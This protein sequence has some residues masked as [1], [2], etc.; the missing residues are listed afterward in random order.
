MSSSRT[1]NVSINMV[2]ALFCQV[3]NLCLNFVSR[4]YFIQALGAEYLGV[5]G[6]FSNVLS[7]LSF[8]ELGIG[9]ALVFSM[10][11]P[12]AVSDHQKLTSLMALY[13]RAYRIIALVVTIAGL[14]YVP[15]IEYTI[16]GHPNIP[17]NLTLIYLLFL[18]NTVVS[19]LVVYK[20]SII[21]ADQKNYIVLIASEIPHIIQIAAQIAVLII[22]H[23]FIGFLVIQIAFT[24][25]GNLACAIIANKKYPYILN[26]PDPLDKE[27]RSEIF[28]NIR[29]MAMYKFGSIILN[30]TDNIIISSMLGVIPV[31]IVSNYVLFHQAANSVIGNI[32]NS[33]TAS[34]GNLNAIASPEKK[35]DIFKKV[36]FIT[37][38]LYGF[39]AS[40]LVVLSQLLIPLWVGVDY[41]LD[42]PT[43]IAIMSGFYV[44]GV[45]TAESHYRMTMGYFVKGKMSPLYSAILNIVL[46]VALCKWIGLIGVFIATPISRIV[47]IGIV[48]TKLIYQLG[49]G[50]NP[51]QYY[52]VNFGY[53]LLI[54]LLSLIAYYCLDLIQVDGWHGLLI[55]TV[56]F[57]II[58]N[59][60]MY[61]IFCRTKMFREILGM[62]KSV[63]KH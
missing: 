60:S 36:L 39:T 16:K 58:F 9:N 56:V 8:A 59:F 17:E 49:F 32:L 54:V 44:F 11:K 35:Y 6:L 29:S 42:L 1:K 7:I 3:V 33:F 10:Y 25:V 23:S 52:Y 30:G 55:K 47:F 51:L 15:F 62:A 63:L 45:H 43:V 20:K 26:K 28:R 46:S 34:I 12:L 50:K 38:W 40:A 22:Y 5:N 21:T 37:V 48:D 14:L 13:K 2:T 57:T 31:G 61:L 18:C 24:F 27:E 53:L 4:T 41:L 19:Y